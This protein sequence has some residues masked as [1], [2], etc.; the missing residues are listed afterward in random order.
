MTDPSKTPE[1]LLGGLA[2]EVANLAKRHAEKDEKDAAFRAAVYD[3]LPAIKATAATVEKH[4]ARLD[5]VEDSIIRT[6]THETRL[7][8]T[9]K[10]V[11]EVDRRLDRQRWLLIGGGTGGGG[12]L[13]FLGGKL[14][15]LFGTGVPP[16]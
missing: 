4:A 12:V 5:A 14:A 6:E 9:E 8:A 10:A 11:S 13:G 1:Y 3:A 7:A 2:T 16:S 15:A